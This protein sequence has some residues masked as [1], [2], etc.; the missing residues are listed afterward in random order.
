MANN[1]KADFPG[2][3]RSLIS[4]ESGHYKTVT[5]SWKGDS[6]WT[7]F[8]KADGG[9]IHVNKDKIEYI[10]TWPADDGEEKI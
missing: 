2:N 10:E 3:M 1:P 6:V 4:F 7:H 5:G 8:K 9:M